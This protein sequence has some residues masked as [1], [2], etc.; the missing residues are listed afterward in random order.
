VLRRATGGSLQTPE[1]GAEYLLGGVDLAI[2]CTGGSGLDSALRLVRAGG[3]VVLSGIPSAVDLT[4][5]WYRELT[6]IGAYASDS[7][8]HQRSDFD[9]ALSLAGHAPL[10]GYVDATYPL[11]GWREAIGHALAAGRL[12]SVK[13]AFDPTRD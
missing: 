4:P 5:L 8:G 2:E 10:D 12:G 11:S 7:G 1:R 13:V 3:T 6:L 9:D